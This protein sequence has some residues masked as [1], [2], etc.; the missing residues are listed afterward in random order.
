MRNQFWKHQF[1][2]FYIGW[3]QDHCTKDMSND[4]ERKQVY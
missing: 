2:M 1:N 3:I 4:M